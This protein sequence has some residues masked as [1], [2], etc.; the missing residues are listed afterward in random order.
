MRLRFSFALLIVTCILIV[1]AIICQQLAADVFQYKVT[2]SSDILIGAMSDEYQASRIVTLTLMVTSLMD[3]PTTINVLSEITFPNEADA[4]RYSFEP[5]TL[6]S[7][8]YLSNIVDFHDLTFGD[9][10]L[11]R[12]TTP[13]I[14]YICA[15]VTSSVAFFIEVY[16]NFLY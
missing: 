5:V 10:S 6:G 7:T 9:A 11:T 13:A 12:L 2:A 14:L 16:K 4:R 8:G 1:A 3:T 15:V